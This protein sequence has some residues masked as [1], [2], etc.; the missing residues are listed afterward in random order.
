MTIHGLLIMAPAVVIARE[1]VILTAPLS[2]VLIG[3]ADFTPLL[4]STV[5]ADLCWKR[6]QLSDPSSLSILFVY[7][8]Y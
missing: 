5:V 4:L 8:S 2:V 3:T 7:E 1:T 6:I